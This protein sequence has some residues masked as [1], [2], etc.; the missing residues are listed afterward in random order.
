ML[1]RRDWDLT[2]VYGSPMSWT[3][4]ALAGV[5]LIHLSPE[6]AHILYDIAARTKAGPAR[7]VYVR[8][9]RLLAREERRLVER[10]AVTWC[11]SQIDVDHFKRLGAERVKALTPLCRP[12][13]TMIGRVA[14]PEHDVVMLGNW[15]WQQN[16][17]ALRSFVAQVVPLLPAS[18]RI[19]VGG[20]VARSAIRVP[21]NVR[22]LGPVADACAFLLSGKRIAV[23]STSVVGFNLKLLDAIAAGR[24]VVATHAALKLAGPVPAHVQG[25]SDAAAFAAA[26]QAAPEPDLHA[27]GTW[28]AAR[29]KTLDRSIRESLASLVAQ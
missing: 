25:A 17:Q 18:W 28:M 8:E 21:H 14:P 16:A 12:E 5:P 2:I 7:L 1:A 10:A 24:P 23:P 26:L 19:V 20:A 9:A 22:L 11:I 27:V 29:E 6:P 15:L 4:D 13:W 3:L